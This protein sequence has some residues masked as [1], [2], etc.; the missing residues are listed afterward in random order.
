VESKPS[1][2]CVDACETSPRPH[3]NV[4]PDWVAAAIVWKYVVVSLPYHDLPRG[5]MLAA[6]N[7]HRRLAFS[8]QCTAS[9]LEQSRP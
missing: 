2:S 1:R 7:M 3:P 9:E 6:T 5:L 4:L 8:V